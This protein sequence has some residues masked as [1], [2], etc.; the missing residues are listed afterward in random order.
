MVFP[1]KVKFAI[2][3]A[4][5]FCTTIGALLWLRHTTDAVRVEVRERFFDQYNRQQYLMAEQAS[6]TLEEMFSTFQRT[7]DL[8]VSF[9]EG[10][11]VDLQRAKGLEGPLRKIKG[12]LAN[13]A[14]IELT[15]FDKQ[16]TVVAVDPAD[17]Y[18]LGRNYAWR[19][20]YQWARDKGKPGLMYL[21]PF[22][23][24]AG[25]SFRG[26][27]ALIL[28]SGI[29][30]KTGEFRGLVMLVLNFD[31]LVRKYILSIRIGKEGYAWLVDSSNRAV[32]V[33]PNGQ[34]AGKGLEEAFM[35]RW[36]RL[37]ELLESAS[38]GKPGS[39][40]YDYEAPENSGVT[41]R[42][43]VSYHPVRIGNKLW[44]LGVATPEREVDALLSTFLQRQ[45]A[46]ANSLVITT[47]GIAITLLAVFFAWNQFL[48]NQVELHTRDLKDARSRLEST[49]DELLSTKKIAA[50][51]RL[52]LGLVHEIRNP[53]SAIQMNMQMIRKKIDPAGTLKE[54]FTIVEG[55]ILRLNRLLKDMMDFAR[56]RPL[57]LQPADLGELTRRLI[58][59]MSQT[60]EAQ[61]IKADIRIDAPLQIVCDPEQIHQVLLN[62]VLNAIDAM[63]E[64]TNERRLVIS[65]ARRNETVLLQVSDTG[66][67]IPSEM[68]EKLFDPFVTTRA[69]GGGLG[70]SILQVIVMRHGGSVTV[71][72]EPDTG[73]T[74]SIILPV[75]GPTETPERQA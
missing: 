57:N 68:T 7:L 54:N 4:L 26:D 71:A 32:L 67:G 25:G 36:P 69:S 63:Q 33:D 50:V 2:L 45:E 56:T 12:A 66:K 20:Y 42:K 70:L 49:F 37:Y 64:L 28:V 52:A 73:T 9:F 10:G 47:L 55:E 16:G 14:A 41:I 19:E 1:R 72:S 46:F 31:E 43:L 59:L 24:L 60:L 58:Q 48:S 6:R 74:F 34:I 23:R 3:L 44:T 38:D 39:S 8:A 13:T 29:Y 22:M 18:T 61:R 40:W 11:T 35:P 75:K 5:I 17:A 21:S 15:V 30:S 65:A 62:L 27:M 53:L 51:G